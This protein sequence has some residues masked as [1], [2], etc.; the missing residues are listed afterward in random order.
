MAN[1]EQRICD[2][3]VARPSFEGVLHF[4]SRHGAMI[5]LSAHPPVNGG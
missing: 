2:V 3:D 5:A 4:C 1:G